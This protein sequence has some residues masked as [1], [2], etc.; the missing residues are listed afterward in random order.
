MKLTNYYTNIIYIY[1]FLGWLFQWF[2]TVPYDTLTTLWKRWVKWNFIIVD[3]FS[4]EI[5]GGN[6]A[7]I[8]L[9][10]EKSNFPSLEIMHKTAAELR[11]SETA[12]ENGMRVRFYNLTNWKYNKVKNGI[13]WKNSKRTEGILWRCSITIGISESGVSKI[14]SSANKGRE[15]QEISE[16]ISLSICQAW[17]LLNDPFWMTPSEDNSLKKSIFIY[18]LLSLLW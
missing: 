7:G 6:A 4:D 17:P 18:R 11:Y 13:K 8:V 10:D 5:F 14:I 15:Y 16:R 3:A 12:F 1:Y 2:R 9:I